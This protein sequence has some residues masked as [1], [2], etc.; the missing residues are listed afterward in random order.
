[1]TRDFSCEPRPSRV[2]LYL[3]KL[4]WS[5]R[6]S[7]YFCDIIQL[8]QSVSCSEEPHAE[9]RIRRR[10]MVDYRWGLHPGQAPPVPIDEFGRTD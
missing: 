4:D 1:M 3:H 5:I 10:I 2:P 7:G 6:Q 8:M 9:T